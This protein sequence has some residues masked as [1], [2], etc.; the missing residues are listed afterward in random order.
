MMALI[1]VIGLFENR[2]NRKLGHFSPQI[3]WLIFI[4][5]STS[6]SSTQQM[7]IPTMVYYIFPKSRRIGLILP[8]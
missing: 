2:L 7:F 3:I 4:L 1:M 6:S 8:G 5:H